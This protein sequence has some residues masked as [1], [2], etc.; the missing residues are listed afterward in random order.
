MVDVRGQLLMAHA[1]TAPTAELDRASRLMRLDTEHAIASRA[2]QREIH[3]RLRALEAEC[4]SARVGITGDEEPSDAKGRRAL[5]ADCREREAAIL[6][7]ER[8]RRDGVDARSDADRRRIEAQA[9][10]SGADNAARRP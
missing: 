2:P 3:V 1:D 6:A 4:A 8:E 7:E 9:T 10:A 5:E